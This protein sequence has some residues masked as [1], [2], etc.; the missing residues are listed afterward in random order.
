MGHEGTKVL[1]RAAS[2]YALVGRRGIALRFDVLAMYRLEP[3]T[4]EAGGE[5]VM[6]ENRKLIKKVLI[7]RLPNT[8]DAEKIKENHKNSLRSLCSLWLDF[9]F[10]RFL[11]NTGLDRDVRCNA[12]R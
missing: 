5:R 1:L 11:I 6:P 12:R 3:A 4:T 9:I 8:E 2:S 7:Y 10:R